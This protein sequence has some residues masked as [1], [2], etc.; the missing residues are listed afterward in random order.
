ML[1][2]IVLFSI[3]FIFVVSVVFLGTAEEG[4]IPIEL[5]DEGTTVNVAKILIDENTVVITEPGEYLVTG[6]LSNGML[7]IDCDGDKVILHLNNVSIH[8]ENGPAIYVENG[9]SRVEIS[10]AESSENILSCGKKLIYIDDDEPN[11]VIFSRSDLTVSGSG[12][13]RVTAEAMDGIVSK[14]DLKIQGGEL[15]IDAARHGI[16]GKDAVEITGGALDI[17]AGKDGIKSTNEKETE[18]GYVSITDSKIHIACGDDPIQFVTSYRQE[19]SRITIEM[20]R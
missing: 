18:W 15:Y 19:N 12:I 1:K 5:K 14:D 4:L 2:K 16:R 10:I 8:N 7:K 17:K 13:L 3:V 11:G 6:S 20:I 9:L